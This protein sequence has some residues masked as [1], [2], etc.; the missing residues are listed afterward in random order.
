MKA[1]IAIQIMPKGVEDSEKIR[2]I[3]LCIKHI[4]SKGLNYVVGP[5]ETA[6][7]GDSV[8]ELLEIVKELQDLGV[9]EGAKTMATFMKLWYSPH[10][11]MTIEEKTEKH[12]H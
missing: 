7:E 5:F 8:E 2:I 10:G 4:E 3:D 11:V 6:I 1:S 12:K 9:K